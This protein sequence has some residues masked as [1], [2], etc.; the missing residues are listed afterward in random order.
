MK[1]CAALLLALLL[2]LSAAAPAEELSLDRLLDEIDSE[3]EETKEI[4]MD[5]LT[6]EVSPDRQS[7]FI[8]KPNVTLGTGYH[9]IA[10]NIYDSDSNPV[11]YFYSDEARVAATTGYGGLFNV[12]VVVTDTDTGMTANR[13]IGWTELDWPHGSSLS[14]GKATFEISP[15]K[16]SIFIDRPSIACRSGKVT[17]AYN[18]YDS[19]SKPVNYFY[20]TQKR[21][22]AT[23]GYDGKF[24]VFIVVTDTVTGE[25]NT[26]NI[27]WQVLGN[28]S[29]TDPP[30][31]NPPPPTTRDGFIYSVNGWNVTITG[32]V[33]TETD[34]VIPDRITAKPVTAIG[35]RAFYGNWKITSVDM[36]NTITS[37]GKNAFGDCIALKTIRI[38]NNAASIG[39]DCFYGCVKL[40]DVSLPDSVTELGESA[41]SSCNALKTVTLGKN[42]REI[43]KNTFLRCGIEKIT[44]PAGLE[45][46]G[47][48]AFADCARLKSITI[49]GGVYAIGEA[50]FLRCNALVDVVIKD[51]VSL[52]GEDAFRECESLASITIPGSCKTVG[53]GAFMRCKKLLSAELKDG[54]VTISSAA[55]REC[56]AMIRAIIPKSVMGIADDA[57]LYCS[58]LTIYG[59]NDSIAREWARNHNVTFVAR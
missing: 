53:E 42:I 33:G 57:F 10:Y 47:G 37:I 20:S 4:A 22:A 59:S 2:C 34:I 9:T 55:F 17:I 38:S 39:D 21:V 19:A 31:T 15:D 12:F 58:D 11:N 54:V 52:I 3:A 7:I 51:G 56:R 35:D 18:I 16:K 44:L 46:L 25:S 49:P 32:Y 1:R 6:F 8:N 24:N 14:V 36:P 13:N 23:P 50:A 27:G 41:F 30:V 29:V 26:Q 48:S 5:P 40:A 43:K 45:T 28:P